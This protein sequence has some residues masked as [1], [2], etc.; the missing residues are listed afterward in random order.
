MKM[1]KHRLLSG[2]IIVNAV[3]SLLGGRSVLFAQGTQWERLGLAGQNINGLTIDPANPARLFAV[4]SGILLSTDGGHTW[5][6]YGAGLVCP[7]IGPILIDPESSA[8]L[9]TTISCGSGGPPWNGLLRTTDG[10]ASWNTA[11]GGNVFPLAMDATSPGILYGAITSSSGFGASAN[12]VNFPPMPPPA[13][14]DF[15][16]STDGGETWH[17]VVSASCLSCFLVFSTSRLTAGTLYAAF[18][19]SYLSSSAWLE[20]STDYGASWTSIGSSGWVE[21]WCLARDPSN[22][23]TMLACGLRNGNGDSTIPGVFRSTDAGVT[24]TREA[25]GLP[26]TTI[27]SLVFNPM[28]P[29]KVFAASDTGGVFAST[30]GG[31]SWGDSSAGLDIP[32]GTHATL[33]FDPTG[34]VLYAA[35]LNGLFALSFPT[36][37]GCTPD[38]KTLCLGNGRFL[39]DAQ[40][41][42][43]QGN[44]GLASVVPGVSSSNSGVM[45]FFGPDNWELLI[46]VLNG[47]GVN[48]NY[49]VFGAAATNVA[50]TIQVTDTQTAEVRTY[51]NPLGTT[52]P[53]ITDT[54]AFGSCP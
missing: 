34:S 38:P 30:D 2:A 9:Y 54:A 33:T 3:V 22:A 19:S 43:F 42:D 15:V 11:L 4:T 14:T 39:V 50:Y 20:R 10:G 45:W 7:P 18:N 28:D 48:G 27:G 17:T 6:N 44:S 32:P 46:K 40:W 49:W 24:W 35:S 53:A 13:A 21:M 31:Q 37:A 41:T 47:C 36:T 16:R 5:A 26:D 8:T 29:S 52:S 1:M 12:G 25:S 23:S 51:T